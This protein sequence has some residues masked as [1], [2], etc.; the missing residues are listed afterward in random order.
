M[1]KRKD[2]DDNAFKCLS[3]KFQYTGKM[4]Y[5][6]SPSINIDKLMDSL[7]IVTNNLVWENDKSNKAKE[8]TVSIAEKIKIKQ[9][10]IQNQKTEI[11]RFEKKLTDLID[12][13]TDGTITKGQFNQKKNEYQDKSLILV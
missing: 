2:G 12:L 1:H 5:C 11:K 4:E 6:G 10:E 3:K 7:F 13:L 9:I 8:Q